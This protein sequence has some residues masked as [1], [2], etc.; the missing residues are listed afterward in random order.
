LQSKTSF[1]SEH[2]D[3][4]RKVTSPAGKGLGKG[5]VGPW[6]KKSGSDL[7]ENPVEHDKQRRS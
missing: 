7:N 2:S 4:W 5:V 6:R 1:S 3:V